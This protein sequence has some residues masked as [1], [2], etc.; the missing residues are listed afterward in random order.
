[1]TLQRTM[2]KIIDAAEPSVACILVSRS[3]QYAELGEGPSAADKGKLGSFNPLRHRTFGNGPRRELV[4][5][6]DL[7]NPERFRRLMARAWQSTV[8]IWC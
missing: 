2:H 4:K 3:D 1:M 7:A 6:L 8:A 5:R